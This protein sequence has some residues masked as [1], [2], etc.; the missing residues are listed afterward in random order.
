MAFDAYLKLD[1]I[2]GESTSKGFTGFMEVFNFSLGAANPVTIG[3]ASTGAGGGKAVLQ[4]FSFTKKTDSASP[5]LYQACVTGA[6]LATGSVQLRKAGG[7]ALTYLTF[8]FKVIFI[9]S[10]SWSGSTGGDDSPTEH[11]SAAFGTLT[12]DYQAQDSTGAPKGGA[13]HAGWNVQ[14][15]QPA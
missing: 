9:E 3:S 4:P 10:I 14:T 8:G 15:N 12:V 6:H 1:T 7:T 13:I 11:V 2:T 5:N